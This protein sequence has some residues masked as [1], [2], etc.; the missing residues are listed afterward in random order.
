MTIWV[1][2]SLYELFSCNTTWPTRAHLL[3][4]RGDIGE[5]PR[6]RLGKVDLA[7][8]AG[9]KHPIDVQRWKWTAPLTTLD[10]PSSV[11]GIIGPYSERANVGPS[12][13]LPRWTR[14]GRAV[15][16][17]DDEMAG[18]GPG[19]EYVTPKGI[20]LIAG[21]L[22]VLTIALMV[23]LMMLWPAC[24]VDIGRPT[25][26]FTLT[27]VTPSVGK[28]GGGDVVT[29]EGTGFVKGATTA[30]FGGQAATDVSVVNS[31]SLTARTPAH[32]AGRVDV[33]VMNPDKNSDTLT[34]AFI[35]ALQPQAPLPKPSINSLSPT[36]GPVGGGQWVTISGSGFSGVTTVRFGGVHA[37]NVRFV[38]DT[39]L[40]VMAPA[41]AEGKV[42]VIVGDGSAA[43]V[44]NGYTYTC[45]GAVPYRLFL[46]V[47]FAGALG[48]ALHG[49]RSLFWYVGN[50][51]L[52]RSWLL[53]YWLLPLSGAAIAV[54]FFLV[55]YAG[56]YT[57]QGTG[58]FILIG[59]AALVGM[60][61]PQAAEKLKMIAEGLLTSA[62][63]GANTVR[64]QAPTRSAVTLRVTS[65]SQS[66]GAE[67]GGTAVTIA[68]TG[69]E[70]GATVKFGGA[71]ATN[72][73][74][75]DGT[76]IMATT[77]PHAPGSVDVEVTSASGQ[78]HTLTAGYRYIGK[79]SIASIAPQS[80]S[81]AGGQAVAITG[82]RLS[83][84]TK[85][86]FGGTPAT[87]MKAVSDNRIE[88]TT[89][90]HASGSVDVAVEAGP[91]SSV[92]PGGYSY[93]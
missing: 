87:A 39:T 7:V 37:T 38:G 47:A 5:G 60:F 14:T 40:T 19:D 16:M 28:V 9:G 81:S 92:L 20:A 52:R 30:S 66:S 68:G 93:T 90:A 11:V 62:P 46:M 83:E 2:P 25:T 77:P 55:A 17:A 31:T 72:V 78:S 27:S 86:T 34:G 43:T 42:D 74:V 3:L 64:P 15:T 84:V 69:F 8:L 63:T 59:L 44:P 41:H 79:P 36:A 73:K 57:V 35:Y 23:G 67:S 56:L 89:P 13:E 22:V 71:A 53:M 61:S 4:H 33:A 26:A 58:S 75:I 6:G 65:V 10:W 85:V 88:A 18:R 48:G 50:R 70:T 76:S 29:L 12:V 45:W 1:V 54:V 91:A 51:D 82:T 49:L 21:Y 24:D 80:G 32:E